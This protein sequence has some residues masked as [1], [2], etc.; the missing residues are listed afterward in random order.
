MHVWHLLIALC[1]SLCLASSVILALMQLDVD[2]AL[3]VI[4]LH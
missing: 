1:R 4:L 3:Q 2:R